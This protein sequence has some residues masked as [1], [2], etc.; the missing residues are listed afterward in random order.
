MAVV[1]RGLFAVYPVP[2]RSGLGSVCCDIG[3]RDRAW[4]WLRI[5]VAAGVADPKIVLGVLVEIFGGNPVPGGRRFPCQGDIPFEDLLGG[6]TDPDIGAV[7]IKRLIGLRKSWLLSERPVWSE[8]AARPLIWSCSHVIHDVG[9]RARSFARPPTSIVCSFARPW[10]RP[11]KFVGR[12]AVEAVLGKKNGRRSI[13][14]S[15]LD[16]RQ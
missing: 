3:R 11:S 12:G 13:G 15:S 7:A 16:L 5:T 14:S 9:D 6:A 2:V 1:R 10:Q 4:C 8:A